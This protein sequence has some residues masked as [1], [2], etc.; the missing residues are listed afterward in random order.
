MQPNVFNV[1]V[2]Q[3][4]TLTIWITS[5]LVVPELCLLAFWL[6]AAFIFVFRF[7]AL[8]INVPNEKVRNSA[9]E[10]ELELVQG[11]AGE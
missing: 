1:K 3:V 8:V 5:T 7:Q 2:I 9:Q 6:F 11:D 4:E 10:D